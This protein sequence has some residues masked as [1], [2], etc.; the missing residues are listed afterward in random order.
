[1]DYNKQ[2]SDT[3]VIPQIKSPRDIQKNKSMDDIIVFSEKE[4]QEVNDKI[5]ELQEE[6]A[7]KEALIES[8]QEEVV[9]KK[10]TKA[11]K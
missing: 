5:A 9:T 3:R 2:N 10:T 7:K 8:L 1:M 11:S 6:L 4:V